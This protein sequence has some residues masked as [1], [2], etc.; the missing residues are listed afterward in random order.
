MEDQIVGGS[1]RCEMQDL[2]S[3][4][5]LHPHLIVISDLAYN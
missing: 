1:P 5:I 3:E 2:L 4:D